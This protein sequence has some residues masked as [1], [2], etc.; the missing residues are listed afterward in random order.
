MNEDTDDYHLPRL[1]WKIFKILYVEVWLEI[2]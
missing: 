1:L 2:S